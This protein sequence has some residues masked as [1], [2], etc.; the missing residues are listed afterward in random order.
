MVGDDVVARDKDR[1]VLA[2]LLN[3]R[4]V[5]K[6][7]GQPSEC[8][9]RYAGEGW[10]RRWQWMDGVGVTRRGL[11][12]SVAK[13]SS[14]MNSPRLG[15]A[16]S[17]RHSTH[18]PLPVSSFQHVTACQQPRAELV[19]VGRTEPSFPVVNTP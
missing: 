5:D 8:V 12:T 9:G 3:R 17:Q 15:L 10:Q 11:S 6:E 1:R 13:P 16:A 7:N 18:T 2:C 14:S 19:V 4:D